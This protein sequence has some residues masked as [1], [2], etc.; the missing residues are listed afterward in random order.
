[1]NRVFAFLLALVASIGLAFAAVNVNTADKAQLESLKGIGPVKA[2]AIIDYRAQHGP[3]RSLEDLDKVPGIGK[4]T[5]DKIRDDVSF[6]GAS[7]PVSGS[8]EAKSART[9]SRSARAETGSTAS[10]KETAPAKS[11]GKPARAESKSAKAEPKTEPKASKSESRSAK[12]ESKAAKSE[13]KKEAAAGGA[14]DINS[15]SAKE[16][17]DLPGVGASRAKAIVKG[18]PYRAKNDLVERKIVPQNV[19]DQIKDRIV[20]H[21][22]K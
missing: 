12:S 3:F 4:G 2:Q 21:Q 8:S 10:T 1:M 7:A 19:Y 16:L 15:A 17:E 14:V 18:R 13:A 5:L 20:A 11:E 9:E 22:K 6:S